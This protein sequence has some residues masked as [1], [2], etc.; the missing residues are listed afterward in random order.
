MGLQVVIPQD[1]RV[2]QFILPEL[3]REVE[4][5]KASPQPALSY[6]RM[7]CAPDVNK[8]TLPIQ[9]KINSFHNH[10]KCERIQDAN[11]INSHSIP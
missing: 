5:E 10:L 3:N 11:S 2:S 6:I 1:Q 7:F 9:Y 4:R 8:S